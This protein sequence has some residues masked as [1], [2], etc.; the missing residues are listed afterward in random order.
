[1]IV[2]ASSTLREN[3]MLIGRQIDAGF[4]GR[5]DLLAFAPDERC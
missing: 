4:G 5:L 1:M 2:A 3:W